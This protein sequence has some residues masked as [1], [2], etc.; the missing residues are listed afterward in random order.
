MTFQSFSRCSYADQH[1]G[2]NRGK[3]FARQIFHL[4]L[5]GIPTSGLSVA[6]P[7]L[8]TARLPAAPHSYVYFL[9]HEKVINSVIGL[10]ER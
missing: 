3:C 1:T 9:S 7:T 8:L 5:L 10:C 4:V 2:A 6:G